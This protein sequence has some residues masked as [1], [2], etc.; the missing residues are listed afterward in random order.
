M[1][2][3]NLKE[4]LFI[5][6]RISSMTQ[7]DIIQ[8]RLLFISITKWIVISHTFTNLYVT[9]SSKENQNMICVFLYNKTPR[10][11]Y[12]KFIIIPT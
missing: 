1:N 6:V 10:K 9:Q 2:A 12:I 4:I 8:I 5:I 3:R 11:N 7:Q